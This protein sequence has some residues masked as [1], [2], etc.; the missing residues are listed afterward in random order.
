MVS[1]E[2]PSGNSL[3]WEFA[4]WIV[5]VEHILSVSEMFYRGT[6]RFEAATYL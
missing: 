3:W 5:N 4:S 1:G 2:F 6:S